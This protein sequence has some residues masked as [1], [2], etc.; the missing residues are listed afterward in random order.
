MVLIIFPPTHR[1]SCAS[2]CNSD[3]KKLFGRI[4]IVFDTQQRE[5]SRVLLLE[6]KFFFKN[7]KL[8]QFSIFFLKNCFES[9]TVNRLTVKIKSF[10]LLTSRNRKCIHRWILINIKDTSETQLLQMYK[11]VKHEKLLAMRSF[12]YYNLLQIMTS[13]QGTITMKSFKNY[14]R[15]W[16]WNWIHE[17]VTCRGLTELIN[18]KNEFYKNL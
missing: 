18:K 9:S 1:I 5:Q 2:N 4:E 17:T 6:S 3:E 13:T 10:F 11:I 7:F 14:M 12:F 15:E 16:K 8:I